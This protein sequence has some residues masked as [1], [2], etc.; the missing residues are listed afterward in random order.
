MGGLRRRKILTEPGT[1]NRQQDKLNHQQTDQGVFF[2]K[3]KMISVQY[4]IYDNKGQRK[5]K[6]YM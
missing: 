1:I 6:T 3:V 5:S 4:K 2:E